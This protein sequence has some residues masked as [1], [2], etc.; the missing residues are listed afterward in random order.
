MVVVLL[1]LGNVSP[2]GFICQ[3]VGC[4]YYE[5][6]PALTILCLMNASALGT[7]KLHFRVF[8]ALKLF[9]D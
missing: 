5:G 9:L 1:T 8:D 7:K 6:E 3:R 2:K 4:N